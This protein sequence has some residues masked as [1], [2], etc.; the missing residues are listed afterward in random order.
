[1]ISGSG[2]PTSSADHNSSSNGLLAEKVSAGYGADLVIR[3]VSVRVPKGEVATVI[4]P[5]GSGK[6][7]FLKA[8]TGVIRTSEGTVV[9]TGEDITNQGTDTIMRRGIGYV[10]QLND[11]FAPLTVQENLEAGG[12]MLPRARVG[13]AIDRIFGVFPQLGTM[14]RRIAG[15]LSGGERKMLAIGRALMVEP[16]VLILDEP[17][18]NL[19]PALA[20]AVLEDYVQ[21]LK[22]EGVAVLLVEQRAR[23]ALKVSDWGYVMVAGSVLLSARAHELAA[24]EDMGSLFLGRANAPGSARIGTIGSDLV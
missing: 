16:P 8:I 21:R 18:A 6:S 20:K 11:V 17:T 3:S 15:R 13:T 7:T 14:R 1:M 5:N 12:Y 10:P 24:R 23:E 4:G 22:A 9:L 2:M 19:S